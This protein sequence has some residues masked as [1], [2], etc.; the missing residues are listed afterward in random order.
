MGAATISGDTAA[1][2]FL[3]PWATLILSHAAATWTITLGVRTA[4]A[5]C[6]AAASTF[7]LAGAALAITHTD[8]AAVDRAVGAAA[9]FLFL[10]ALA[11]PLPLALPLTSGIVPAVEPGDDTAERRT[12]QQTQSA[13]SRRCH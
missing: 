6:N 2:A 11:L 13:P 5:S 7:L 10:L 9:L 1:A 3:L 4:T 8:A 12:G